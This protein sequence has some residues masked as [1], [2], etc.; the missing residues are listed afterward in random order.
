M[1]RLFLLFFTDV[2]NV[3]YLAS[4]IELYSQTL[5]KEYFITHRLV[6]FYLIVYRDYR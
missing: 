4:F 6:F 3:A 5:L 2:R 1:T